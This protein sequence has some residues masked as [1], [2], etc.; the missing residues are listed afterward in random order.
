MLVA[1]AE[2]AEEVLLVELFEGVFDEEL[3]VLFCGG[4]FA[5]DGLAGADVEA[6]AF[7]LGEA[8]RTRVAGACISSLRSDVGTDL[9][10]A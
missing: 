5:P 6:G 2:F 3:G 1:L 8:A 4:R 10:G 9:A 7:A